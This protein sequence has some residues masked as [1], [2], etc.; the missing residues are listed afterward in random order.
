MNGVADPAIFT[1]DGGPSI[2]N[3][4]GRMGVIFR[5]AD[6]KRVAGAGALGGWDQVRARLKGDGERPALFIFS[7]CNDLIPPCRRC[8]TIRIGRKMSIP[9]PRI[10]LPMS[11]AMRA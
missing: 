5:P 7:T 10:M 3:R 9:M 1:E 2:A 6:N 11:C 4:M 8:S